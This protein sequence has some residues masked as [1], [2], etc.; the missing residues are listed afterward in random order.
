[1][2]PFEFLWKYDRTNSSSRG[3]GLRGGREKGSMV[4]DGHWP[5]APSASRKDSAIAA[6]KSTSLHLSADYPV[7]YSGEPRRVR[8]VA[9]SRTFRTQKSLCRV[10]SWW[11]G[12][13]LSSDD[14][15]REESAPLALTGLF[16]FTHVAT[17]GPCW[18]KTT[19]SLWLLCRCR[20]LKASLPA[21]QRWWIHARS[22]IGF[23]LCTQHRYTISQS[24]ETPQ[25]R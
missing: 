8:P 22:V 1:M 13:S 5:W 9:A 2:A 23:W 4:F 3:F 20:C 17:V 16:D 21:L 18:A 6:R 25:D 14:P 11:W 10:T 7:R 12:T 24:T 19:S 15:G